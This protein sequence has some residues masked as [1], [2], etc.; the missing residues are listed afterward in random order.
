MKLI[1]LIGPFFF[2]IFSWVHFSHAE[3]DL[4]LF[5]A[6]TLKEF[7]APDA[8]QGAAVD[9][10]YFYAIDNYV[11]AKYDKT[12]GA[13]LDRWTGP[14]NKIIRHINS[15]YASNDKLWCANSNYSEVPMASSIE[16]FTTSPLTHDSSH[17]LGIRDEGSLTWTIAIEDG[18]LAGF[19]NYDNKG[20]MPHKNS[21]YSSVVLFDKQWRRTGGWMLPNSV[22]EVMAPYSAS[23]G[24]LGPDGFLYLTGH[25]KKEMYV[26]G[27]PKMGP[28]LIHIATVKID[29]EG[30]AFHWDRFEERILYGVDR[31]NGKIKKIRVPEIINTNPHAL[32]F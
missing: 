2:V 11:I 1:N 14:E 32:T 29:L 26:L 21:R 17:S 22:L 7:N 20:G 8:D 10:H 30:Q 27:K 15:C 31:R 25:D 6:E 5:D 12:D 24:D 28:K 13:L 3:N 4:P 18:Y 16:I 23:G 9:K 19:A